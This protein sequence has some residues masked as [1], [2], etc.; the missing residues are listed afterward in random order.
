MA[1]T[2][3]YKIIFANQGRFAVNVLALACDGSW[4]DAIQ[5]YNGKHDLA[6]ID[7]GE[8]NAAHLEEMLDQDD[9]VLS[10][11]CTDH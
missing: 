7:V 2:R 9:N 8:E 6:V 3:S 4:R 5:R 11:V 10:Y 1:A